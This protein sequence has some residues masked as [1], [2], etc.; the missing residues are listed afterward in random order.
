MQALQLLQHIH[1]SLL[2]QLDLLRPILP[3]QKL[4][5]GLMPKELLQK[6]A[7]EE[8]KRL[9]RVAPTACVRRR[10]PPITSSDKTP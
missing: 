3:L 6:V 1:H 8:P 10:A 2:P 9:F 5:R 7:V 4:V